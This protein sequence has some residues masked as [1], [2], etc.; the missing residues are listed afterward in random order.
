M[1]RILTKL[2]TVAENIYAMHTIINDEG[3]RVLYGVE[4][5]EEAQDMAKKLLGRVGYEDLKIV[6]DGPYHIEVKDGVEPEQPQ[7]FYSI[8]ILMDEENEI[9][10][11]ATP[12][13]IENIVENSS[14]NTGLVFNGLIPSF[15]L[16]INGEES[17]TGLPEW[18]DFRPLSATTGILY[19]NGVTDNYTIKIV[20]DK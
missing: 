2:H 7:S 5:L 6:N 20:I 11:T 16:I 3:D 19:F 4:T 15:H 9:E 17:A 18:I 12:N 14:V 13:L 1:Y 8:E 10:C